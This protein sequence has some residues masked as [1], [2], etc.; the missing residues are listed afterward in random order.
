MY[1]MPLSGPQKVGVIFYGLA[2]G[3]CAVAATT[4]ASAILGTLV[5]V[6]LG[7]A[8]LAGN[9]GGGGFFALE[10]A[11]FGFY[12]GIV[13]GAVVCWKIWRSRLRNNNLVDRIPPVE[14]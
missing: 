4:I 1:V 5:A 13:L 11:F 6:L 3:V 10:A 14:S 8:H 9:D 7:L 12:A 2:M